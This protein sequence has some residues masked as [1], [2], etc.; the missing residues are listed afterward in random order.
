LDSPYACQLAANLVKK[1]FS[2]SQEKFFEQATS[3][4]EEETKEEVHHQI[5]DILWS[6]VDYYLYDY[7]VEKIFSQ[8]GGISFKYGIKLRFK[9]K[10]RSEIRLKTRSVINFRVKLKIKLG[11]I[12]VIRHMI[13]L[14]MKL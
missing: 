7:V 4:I 2:F 6:K 8:I 14:K 12:F 11:F 9:S 3:Q 13:I 10:T 1:L 5:Q